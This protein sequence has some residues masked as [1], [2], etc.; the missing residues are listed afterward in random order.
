MPATFTASRGAFT[1][2]LSADNWTLQTEPTTMAFVRRISWGGRTSNS[3]PYRT[4][5][6]IPAVAPSGS[7]TF[8]SQV[9]SNHGVSTVVRAVS[10]YA[11]TAATL[12]AESSNLFAQDWN[13]Q[14]GEGELCFARSK[15]WVIMA[16]NAQTVNSFLCCRNTQG[17][18]A[19]ASEYSVTWEV[20]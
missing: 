11:T 12:P 9:A 19:N 3:S 4:R 16:L 13:A 20:Y 1:P 10:A 18:D 14:G 17:A 5:W 8:L 7:P 6:C 2:S 15:A